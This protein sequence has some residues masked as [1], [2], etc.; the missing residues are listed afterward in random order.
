LDG[1]DE[2]YLRTKNFNAE[3][4]SRDGGQMSTLEWKK[5]VFNLMNTLSR[6]PE[7]YHQLFF[8]EQVEHKEEKTADGVPTIHDKKTEV[9]EE[10]K[11]H[12]GYDWHNRNSFVDHFVYSFEPHEFI[13]GTF[14]ELGDFVNQPMDVEMTKN[15]CK[16]TRKGGL[17]YHNGIIP[18]VLTKS[19]RFD[20]NSIS[21]K[22]EFRGDASGTYVQ[23]HNIHMASFSDVTFNGQLLRRD[24]DVMSLTFQNRELTMTDP[25]T[26]CKLNWKWEREMSIFIYVV[27]TVSLAVD[28]ME[29]TAQGLC[30]LASCGRKD[31]FDMKTT[32]TVEG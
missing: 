21:C 27:N 18:A 13:S 4:V 9:P 10:M 6:R 28:T 22:M 32:L 11:K 23:E 12:L 26:G 14:H 17:F 30:I 29:L 3:F 25:Y 8:S 24:G 2:V 5:P 20:K 15:G 1:Y 19:Y 7:G 31:A 16:F